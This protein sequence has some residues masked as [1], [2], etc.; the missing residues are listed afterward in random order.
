MDARALTAQRRDAVWL[1]PDAGKFD[2]FRELVES[3]TR[4]GDWPTAIDI[5][6]NIPVYSGDDVRSIAS[7]ADDTLGLLA[8]WNT[9]FDTGPGVIMIKGGMAD[10]SVVD[11][12]TDIFNRIIDEES[13]TGSGG[14]DHFAKPGANNRVWNAA[15]KHCLADPENF[16]AYYASEGIALAARAWLGRGY[17]LTAQ[18]NRVN[19]GGAAQTAHRDY[20]LGFMNA[21]QLATYPVQAHRFSPNLT[22]QGAIAHCD[23]PIESGPTMLLPY[24]QKFMAG[25]VAYNRD[26]YQAYFAD[27]HVQTELQKGDLVFFNPAVMHGAGNNK[28]KDIRR[29]ANLLQIGSAFGR[30]IE[31]VD[32]PAMSRALYPVLQDAMTS[33]AWHQVQNAIAASAEGYAFPTNLD[34]DPPVGGLIPLSHAELMENALQAGKSAADWNAE[35]DAMEARRAP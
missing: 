35:V 1:G 23:M 10:T 34:L 18:V 17:Q 5:V 2:E 27:H 16:A 25:Y 31:S 3:E 21:D 13:A 11:A 26:E 15:Q 14:G 19:P 29:F 32:R 28:S 22:L 30:S 7:N 6:S 8:E 33:M 4:P 24:S 9:A 12:A 20:H